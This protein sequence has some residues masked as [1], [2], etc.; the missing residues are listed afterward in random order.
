MISGI[1]IVVKG[2]WSC[3][4]GWGWL[5]FHWGRDEWV[6]QWHKGGKGDRV[7]R[8]CHLVVSIWA[9]VDKRFLL[10]LMRCRGL[11]VPAG[12]RLVLLVV[13]LGRRLLR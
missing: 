8:W 9:Q 1:L 6:S 5:M 3:H 13:E 2:E 10:R 4:D 12:R 11:V 7:I